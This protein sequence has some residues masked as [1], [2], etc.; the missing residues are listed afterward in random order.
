MMKDYNHMLNH[1]NATISSL[2]EDYGYNPKLFNV[3][4]E[5]FMSNLIGTDLRIP[6]SAY[7]YMQSMPI[8]LFTSF[9]KVLSIVLPLMTS[10][11]NSNLLFVRSMDLGFLGSWHPE[12][13]I[14][15]EKLKWHVVS[16]SEA[17]HGDNECY[18]YSHGSIRPLPPLVEFEICVDVNYNNISNQGFLSDFFI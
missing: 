10:S 5:D 7:A 17:F 3:S 12:P 6:E 11:R 8:P 9:T 4:R 13:V 14:Q 16:V 15:S 1:M 18:C 2:Q